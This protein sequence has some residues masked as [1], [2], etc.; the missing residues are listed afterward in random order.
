MHPYL[1]TLLVFISQHT[2]MA[3][4][5][6]FLVS[7][8]ESLALVGLLMPG[9]TIMF[10]VGAVVATGSLGLAPVL[11]L[12]MAGAVAGDG[13][14]YWLGHHYRESLRS[15]WPFSRYPEMLSKGEAFFHRHGGK[16]VLFG[17]FVGPVRPVIPVVAG[18]LGMGPAH[19]AV[20][21][22]LSAIGWALAYVLP[23]V[24][25]G[26]SL[27]M[28]G[29][30]SAR[31]A[32]VV[33]VLVAG[34]WGFLWGCR[35]AVSLLARKGPVWLGNL[36]QWACTEPSAHGSARLVQ[37]L[38]RFL[39]FRGKTE[40]WP[41]AFLSVTLF[42]AGWAFL[43]VLQDVLSKDPL[44]VADQAVYHFFQ[45]VR[46][47][48][49]DGVFVAV[50]ELGDSFVN[51]SL[52]GAVLLVLLVKRCYRAAGFWVL[53]V[54]GGL[55]GVQ[56][57]K[58]AIHL[59]RPVEMYHGAS[60]YGFPSGHAAMSVIL[61]GFLGILLGRKVSGP[62]RWGL[63]S[64]VLFV[65]FVI[66]FS[67]LYL[68]AHWL[69]DVLGGCFIGTSWTAFMGI[70]WMKASDEKVPH[71][72]LAFTVV[73]VIALAGSWHVARRHG[74][75]LAFYAPRHE[76]KTVTLASWRSGG[77]RHLPAWRVDMEGELEQPLTVQW[78]GRPEELAD[79]LKTKG[80]RQPQPL[81]LKGFL[82]MFAPDTPI[83]ELPILPRL[84]DGRR[85]R[86]RLVRIH[87]DRRLVLR[88]WDTDVRI[89][90]PGGSPLL[91]GTVEEQQNSSLAGLITVPRDTG[92]YNRPLDLLAQSLGERFSVMLVRRTDQV[93]RS[94]QKGRGPRWGG[95]VL[96]AWHR[97]HVRDG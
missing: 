89:E 68:G 88:L 91:E 49:G 23:G 55:L 13:V 63:F 92:D 44:V 42:V 93:F 70:A 17:R 59:P 85:E 60:A 74:Q 22:V 28:A 52:A 27:A 82:G 83:G 7:F 77:W 76:E 14:S 39:L 5:V 65:S 34:V 46:T 50:T 73:L 97:K 26:T 9:T 25:L 20:V 16:S 62:G 86:L 36:K 15:I 87:G 40:A 81:R 80:W 24:F 38:L 6:V 51:L 4:G 78:V 21:N 47:P 30:V 57:L 41:V 12:A 3:Y 45:S 64:G 75:D 11:L 96:L 84:H 2:R 66:G 32:V 69:S 61:Y 33:F 18:M 48:W 35:R 31:L 90:G 43:G 29:A 53:T 56:L 67:R 79:F 58:W 94:G 71:R 72:L 95:G 19:F 54:L 1:N 10:G 37:R 8:S